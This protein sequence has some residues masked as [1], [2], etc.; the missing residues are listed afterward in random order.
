MRE[1]YVEAA[2]V[3]LHVLDCGPETG[4][5]VFMQHGWPDDITSWLAVADRLVGQGYRC[6]LPSL[7][8]FGQSTFIDATVMRSAQVVALARDIEAVADQLA[9][10]RFVLVGH[11]WGA[12]AVFP[13]AVLFPE[14]ISSVVSV[15]LGWAPG[16]VQRAL[17][18]DQVRCF[19]YQWFLN[20]DIGRARFEKDPVRFCRVMWDT[21]SPPGWFDE[22][23][24][25][26]AASAFRGPDFVEIVTHFYRARY[27]NADLDPNYAEDERRYRGAEQITVPTL[28][29]HGAE[30]QCCLPEL[31]EGL[32]PYFCHFERIVLDNVGHFPQREAPDRVADEIGAFLDRLSRLQG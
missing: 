7:R 3:R 23:T 18:Y 22:A 8:G 9:I 13:A 19:W 26:Q 20:T 5:A 12:R 17:S 10:D 32:E 29:I 30:D 31:S 25:E 28:I 11:D 15:S 16:G 21:W 2:G 14:R 24:W 1:H 27:N 4:P 6:L